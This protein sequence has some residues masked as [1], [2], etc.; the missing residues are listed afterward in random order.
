MPAQIFTG[1]RSVLHGVV[2][3]VVAASLTAGMQAVSVQQA[4]AATGADRSAQGCIGSAGYTWSQLRQECVRLFEAGVPLYNA[5]DPS[6]ASVAYV[7]SGGAAEPLELFLPERGEGILMF[8]RD[9]AWHDDDERYTLTNSADDVLT[10]RDAAGKVLFS[11]RKT[12]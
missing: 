7:I 4:S 1:I 9:G 10:V 3:L 5:E 8:F 11:S 6:A 12:T 2:W